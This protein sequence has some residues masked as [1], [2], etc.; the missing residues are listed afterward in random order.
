MALLKKYNTKIP[1]FGLRPVRLT[2]AKT[3]ITDL[4]SIL[5]RLLEARGSRPGKEIQLLEEEILYLC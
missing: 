3:A 4:D 5:D 1:N 2:G